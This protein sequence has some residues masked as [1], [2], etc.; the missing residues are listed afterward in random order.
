MKK[1]TELRRKGNVTRK[2]LKEFVE[3]NF[4]P[5]GGEL[6]KW[7]PSDWVP[8]PKFIYRIKL[9]EYQEFA[10][11]LNDLWKILGRKMREDI[12]QHPKRHSLL[13]VPHPF[14][15][16]GDRFREF[17]YWDTFWIIKGLLLC[18]M[19]FILLYLFE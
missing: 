9:P 4:E 15:V 7:I 3:Q 10:H 16:P 11:G 1:F 13:Y 19:V 14:V 5:A 2:V 6:D 18:D 8:D 17:Y 12:A